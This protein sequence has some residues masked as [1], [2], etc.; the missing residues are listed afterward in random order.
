MHLL[1]NLP[2]A[3][4]QHD[5]STPHPSAKIELW[6]QDRPN[7]WR[8]SSQIASHEQFGSHTS[9][10][11]PPGISN[12]SLK[13]DV[14]MLWSVRQAALTV[15]TSS[16]KVA[17]RAAHGVASA[18]N[19]TARWIGFGFDMFHSN[20]GF[21]KWCKNRIKPPH[22]ISK[23]PVS[24]SLSLSFFLSFFHLLSFFLSFCPIIVSS[25]LELLPWRAC[26]CPSKDALWEVEIS[27]SWRASGLQMEG[28]Q[29]LSAGLPTTVAQYRC[30]VL[31][32]N[33]M[34]FP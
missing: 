33:M 12:Q 23:P 15:G 6:N 7:L 18:S 3:S 8:E 4:G 1:P 5:P 22:T 32:K 31:Q 17:K 21:T 19:M 16:E 2:A 29:P 11:N 28:S 25:Y 34:T 20:A 30:T 10:F 13:Q 14:M 9:Q 24:L 26:T 27:Q